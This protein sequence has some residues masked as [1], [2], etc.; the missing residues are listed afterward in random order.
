VSPIS[1]ILISGDE[2]STLIVGGLVGGLM[3][4]ACVVTAPKEMLKIF[5]KR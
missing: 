1:T 2:I 3:I 4:G 5:V